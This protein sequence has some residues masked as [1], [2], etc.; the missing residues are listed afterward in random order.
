[1][2]VEIENDQTVIHLVKLLKEFWII[3]IR[4]KF[5]GRAQMA[6]PSSV[7]FLWKPQLLQLLGYIADVEL[8]YSDLTMALNRYAA[9]LCPPNTRKLLDTKVR[10]FM[11]N[12]LKV[13]QVYVIPA[14]DADVILSK[15]CVHVGEMMDNVATVFFDFQLLNRMGVW[16][17][18]PVISHH[19]EYSTVAPSRFLI[20]VLRALACKYLSRE[21]LV[22]K[23]DCEEAHQC[24]KEKVKDTANR[25]TRLW[26]LCRHDNGGTITASVAAA[27]NHATNDNRVGNIPDSCRSQHHAKGEPLISAAPVA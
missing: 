13:E 2:T 11:Q 14:I 10:S 8:T 19:F 23:C 4:S 21:V 15:L 16:Y 5:S 24:A 26:L 22:H 6:V 20:N 1:M 27:T 3:T 9:D 25:Q 12:R 7:E 18:F 17:S